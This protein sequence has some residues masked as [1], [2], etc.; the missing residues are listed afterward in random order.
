MDLNSYR[1]AKLCINCD[2]FRKSRNA[3]D[4]AQCVRGDVE[5]KPRESVSP[6][7][8]CGKFTPAKIGG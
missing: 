7:S 3:Y 5:A 8:Q 6:F 1:P 2:H 4:V